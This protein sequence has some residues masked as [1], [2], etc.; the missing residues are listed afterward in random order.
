MNITHNG[1]TLSVYQWSQKNGIPETTIACRIDRGWSPERAVS[2]PPNEDFSLAI[3][4]KITKN[5]LEMELNEMSIE[6]LPKS[7]SQLIDKNFK[8]RKFG[9]YL[10]TYYPKKFSQYFKETYLPSKLS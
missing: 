3:K 8:G 4:S 7:L 1:E 5:N 9:C 2:E 10:R 6:Q